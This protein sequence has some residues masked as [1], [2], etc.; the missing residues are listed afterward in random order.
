MTIVSTEPLGDDPR[1]PHAAMALALAG[2]LPFLGLSALSVTGAAAL[3]GAGP[4]LVEAEIGYGAVILSFLG[5]IRWGAALT[6]PN[7]VAQSVGLVMSVI[8]S[9]ISWAALLYFAYRAQPIAPL[10]LLVAGFITQGVWDLVGA[11]RGALPRWF[12]RLRLPLTVI[13]IACLATTAFTLP[14]P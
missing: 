8:P 10:A 9:L 6:E 12:A 7:K 2:L 14:Q 1:I 11:R 5:G 4:Q 3:P 13:V